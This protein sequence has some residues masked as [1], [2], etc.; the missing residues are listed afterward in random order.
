MTYTEWMKAVS[1]IVERQCGL[2]I[3]ALPDWLSRDAYDEGLTTREGAE[4]CLRE[5]GFYGYS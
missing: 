5:A 1:A 3:D 2:P 4:M